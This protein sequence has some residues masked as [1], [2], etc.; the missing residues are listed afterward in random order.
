MDIVLKEQQGKIVHLILNR[1]EK[2]NA[3]N[4][5]MINSLKKHFMDLNDDDSV[6]VI[7]LR[8]H[9]EAFCA[10]ADLEYLQE[11][12]KNN[13]EENLADSKN[14]AELFKLIYTHKKI[15]ISQVQGAALAGGCGLATVCDLCY[16]IPE[17]K[18]GYTEVKIGFIPAIV[19]FFLLRKVGE[20]NTKE[21]LLTGKIID[22]ANAVKIGL[23]NEVIEADKI[24]DHVIQ[25]A[26]KLCVETSP[27]S[28]ALTKN[29]I[30]EIQ[31]L[32]L[33]DAMQLAS[34]RNAHAR[35]TDDCK[36]GITAF[37]N[38]EKLKW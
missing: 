22:A 26:E 19:S 18:F 32:S 24:K 36:K 1:A 4:V 15:I 16:A 13:Y 6:R 21:L 23:I 3:L 2:R 9:G 10:G 20:A 12:Q 5:A 29:L 7:I 35:A 38:K 34:G 33:D 37:L 27:S 30:N 17:S 14:L 25:I 8:A 31:S 28:V 11:L